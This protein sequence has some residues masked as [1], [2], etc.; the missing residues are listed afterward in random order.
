[1]IVA[2]FYNLIGLHLH[3]IDPELIGDSSGLPLLQVVL[4]KHQGI[5]NEVLNVLRVDHLRY[6]SEQLIMLWVL[7]RYGRFH[8]RVDVHELGE[9][10]MQTLQEGRIGLKEVANVAEFQLREVL[11]QSLEDLNEEAS[12]QGVRG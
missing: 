7:M 3:V 8:G 2:I 10:G 6:H 11:Q 4:S 12:W 9:E 5:E 1:M